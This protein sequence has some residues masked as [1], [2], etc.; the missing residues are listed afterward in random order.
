MQEAVAAAASG[1]LEHRCIADKGASP[2]ICVCQELE[3]AA[4]DLSHAVHFQTC[5]SLSNTLKKIMC[6]CESL[7]GRTWL[8]LPVHFSNVH[9]VWGWQNQTG[10]LGAQSLTPM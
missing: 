10:K 3:S 9:G 7:G 5:V 8:H 1:Y 4:R 2:H 6:L